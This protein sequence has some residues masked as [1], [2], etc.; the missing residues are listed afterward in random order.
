PLSGPRRW[1]LRRSAAGTASRTKGARAHRGAGRALRV[2]REPAAPFARARRAHSAPASPRSIPHSCRPD[3][4]CLASPWRLAPTHL[5]ARSFVPLCAT[6]MAATRAYRSAPG[7]NIH[8]LGETRPSP[9]AIAETEI[10]S[11]TKQDRENP[12]HA[13]SPAEARGHPALP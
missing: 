10:H 8:L 5:G 7:R 2:T 12:R 9:A 13:E 11:I 6:R 3:C 4:S 1:A